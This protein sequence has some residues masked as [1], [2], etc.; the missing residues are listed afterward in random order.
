MVPLTCCPGNKLNCELS[1]TGRLADL[2]SDFGVRRILEC[3]CSSNLEVNFSATGR[4]L[5]TAEYSAKCDKNGVIVVTYLIIKTSWRGGSH[6]NPVYGS[7]CG[8]KLDV[9][10]HIRHGIAP[11]AAYRDFR[12]LAHLS[13]CGMTSSHKPT[14]ATAWQ[15][16]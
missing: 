5:R 14:S 6:S 13:E 4:G 1:D 8:N 2:Y 7:F 3:L 15:T 16:P 9:S 12:F 11:R 10:V